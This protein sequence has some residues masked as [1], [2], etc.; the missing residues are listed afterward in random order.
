MIMLSLV[1]EERR[2]GSQA[3]S[4]WSSSTGCV[5]AGARRYWQ[6]KDSW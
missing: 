5:C 3:F 6:N 4:W 1:G 2:G